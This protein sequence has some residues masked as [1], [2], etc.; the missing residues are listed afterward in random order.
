MTMLNKNNLKL[1]S[2]LS[3][4]VIKSIMIELLFLC[5]FILSQ[6]F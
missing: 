6:I 4:L 1:L 3:F 5:V 2:F